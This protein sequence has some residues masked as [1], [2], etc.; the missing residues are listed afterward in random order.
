MRQKRSCVFK[1]HEGSKSGSNCSDEFRYES[2]TE[3]IRKHLGWVEIPG[4]LS[5]YNRRQEL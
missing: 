5:K 1:D 2:Q 3:V 4:T